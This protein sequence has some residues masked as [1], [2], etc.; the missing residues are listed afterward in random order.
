[1]T[2][3]A[4]LSRIRRSAD[5]AIARTRPTL[6]GVGSGDLNE[7]SGPA[8]SLDDARN[9]SRCPGVRKPRQDMR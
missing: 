8:S 9:L 1:M 2:V 4:A 7:E 5:P 3:N 6:D